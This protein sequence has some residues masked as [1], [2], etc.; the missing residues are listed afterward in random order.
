[1]TTNGEETKSKLSFEES[2]KKHKKICTG[3]VSNSPGEIPSSKRFLAHAFHI[4]PG[5]LLINELSSN[6]IRTDTGLFHWR[7]PISLMFPQVFYILPWASCSLPT[8]LIHKCNIWK[9]NPQLH[10]ESHCKYQTSCGAGKERPTTGRF[11][12]GRHSRPTSCKGDS[13]GSSTRLDRCREFRP[14][15]PH[16][17]E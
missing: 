7:T 15:P 9:P 11:T 5:K 10:A 17:S 8:Y 1:M 2:E 14:P 6:N 12:P 16:P 4:S 13:V 3:D